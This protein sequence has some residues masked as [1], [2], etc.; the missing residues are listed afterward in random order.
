MLCI[1]GGGSDCNNDVIMTSVTSDLA[2]L[3]TSDAG[4]AET[5]TSSNVNLPHVFLHVRHHHNTLTNDIMKL[6]RS[7]T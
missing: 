3:I 1:E 2:D 6:N 7:A 5:K 4:A